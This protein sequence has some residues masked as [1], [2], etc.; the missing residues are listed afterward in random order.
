MNPDEMELAYVAPWEKTSLPLHTA[1]LWGSS[2][3]QGGQE[4]KE[5]NLWSDEP[6]PDPNA[7]Q[8]M[9]PSHGKLCKKGICSEMAKLVREE[10]RRKREGER[11]GGRRGKGGKGRSSSNNTT[12]TATN[13]SVG[14]NG[15]SNGGGSV[16]AADDDVDEEGFSAVPRGK[17]GGR[18]RGGRGRGKVV[19]NAGEKSMLGKMRAF[20]DDDKESVVGSENGWAN[21]WGAE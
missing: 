21:A 6:P 9:C 1:D 10:E 11:G 20:D 13:R 15:S 16:V 2:E 5:V 7:G 18:G 8:L 19:V 3:G 4:G 17:R 12:T 14:D